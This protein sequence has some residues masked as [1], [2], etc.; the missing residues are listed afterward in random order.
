[1]YSLDIVMWRLLSCEINGQAVIRTS[2][3]EF[4]NGDF[5]SKTASNFF[6]PQYAEERRPDL[7][8][9]KTL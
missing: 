1:M 2:P 9:S 3:E 8:L 4:E 6:R 7:C 5:T